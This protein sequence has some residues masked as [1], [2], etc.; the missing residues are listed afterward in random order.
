[1]T[2]WGI[3]YHNVIVMSYLVIHESGFTRPFHWE[4]HMTTGGLPSYNVPDL[5]I[6]HQ[7]PTLPPTIPKTIAWF[8]SVGNQ[9]AYILTEHVLE[10]VPGQVLLQMPWYKGG[11]CQ[12]DQ[13]SKI[14]TFV[15]ACII[16]HIL[17]FFEPIY[18]FLE[19]SHPSVP[20]AK[21]LPSF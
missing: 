14:P 21:L 9:Q 12:Y 15:K 10:S 16:E 5:S 17:Y 18:Q 2:S 4:A 11:Q 20:L 1:M 19:L 6:C 3:S 8:P 7:F 13:N